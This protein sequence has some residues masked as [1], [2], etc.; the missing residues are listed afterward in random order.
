M[1]KFYHCKT[2]GNK[3]KENPIE[4][5]INIPNLGVQ[6]KLKY[7]YNEDYSECIIELESE[8]VEHLKMV[9]PDNPEK[10]EEKLMLNEVIK[11]G[12]EFSK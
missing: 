10:P 11:K 7:H 9:A 2:K 6:G 5:E 4:P 1:I 12:V 3:T 8:E